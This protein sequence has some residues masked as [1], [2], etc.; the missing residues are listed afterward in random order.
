MGDLEQDVSKAYGGV[1]FALP[2]LF[3]IALL[4]L[5]VFLF[6]E[7]FL[8][9]HLQ[10]PVWP[11]EDDSSLGSVPETPFSVPPEDDEEPEP[12]AVFPPFTPEMDTEVESEIDR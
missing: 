9:P 12:S 6:L 4:P 7:P 1:E 8:H 3:L 2:S 10:Q 5:R 11:L